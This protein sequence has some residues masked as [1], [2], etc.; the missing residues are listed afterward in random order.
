[1]TKK[2]RLLIIGAGAVVVL[3]VAVFIV[4]A[5]YMNKKLQEADS[6][7]GKTGTTQQ[8]SNPSEL[9]ND[10]NQKSSNGDYQAAINLIEGQKNASDPGNQILLAQTYANSGNDTKALEIYK[11]LDA[12]GQIPD[13]QLAT[14]ANAAEQANDIKTAIALYK[15]AETYARNS[16]DQNIDQADVYAYK[17]AE[18]EKRQ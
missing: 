13:D 3:L 18:L 16:K 5:S 7:D 15:R 9:A 4:W 17:V 11:K 12:A 1:M 14:A 6:P 2:R 8:Y 10:V